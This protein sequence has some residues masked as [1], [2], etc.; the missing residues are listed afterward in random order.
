MGCGFGTPENLINA[1]RII[2]DGDTYFDQAVPRR[3]TKAAAPP[4][5]D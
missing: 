4:V 3:H 1:I 5:G 2:N